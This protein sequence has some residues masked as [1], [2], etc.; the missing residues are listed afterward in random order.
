MYKDVAGEFGPLFNNGYA[1]FTNNLYFKDFYAELS[2]LEDKSGIQRMVDCAELWDSLLS[3]RCKL[4]RLIEC[5][6]S[7]SEPGFNIHDFIWLVRIAIKLEP[8]P[9]KQEE[10][11]KILTNFLLYPTN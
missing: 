1:V 3:F 11:K 6:S 4:Y 9:T 8:S 2:C 7:W 5:W 10:L